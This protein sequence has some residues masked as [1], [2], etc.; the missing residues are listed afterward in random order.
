LIV[1]GGILQIAGFAFVAW[2]LDRIRRREFGPWP[3]WQKLK[4]RIR[5]LFGL[6]KVH[7]IELHD[8]AGTSDVALA[9]GI[10]KRAPEGADVDFRLHVLEENFKFLEKE[11]ERH[12][13]EG[14]QAVSALA[15][16]LSEE[17]DLLKQEKAAS[18]L[19]DRE[20]V[21]ASLRLQWW[22]IG[23]FVAGTGLGVWG[24]LI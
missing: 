17:V 11:V 14:E 6:A 24:S 22:G 12:R 18:D 5:R 9:L 23:F 10:R 19:R 2:D 7:E 16:K 4:G 13:Q 21:G 8:V 20:F 1:L 3:P 15:R